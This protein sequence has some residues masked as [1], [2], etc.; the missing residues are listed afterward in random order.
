MKPRTAEESW[1]QVQRDGYGMPPSLVSQPALGL[2]D[3]KR[4]LERREAA[5]HNPAYSYKLVPCAAPKFPPRRSS[6]TRR[7]SGRGR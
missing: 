4:Q 3:A 1:Y 5:E 2:E 6:W 7:S